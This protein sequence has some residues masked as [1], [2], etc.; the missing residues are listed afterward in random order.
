MFCLRSPAYDNHISL[1][2]EVS[3]TSPA[4]ASSTPLSRLLRHLRGQGRGEPE[5][6]QPQTHALPPQRGAERGLEAAQGQAGIAL[7]NGAALRTRQARGHLRSGTEPA[8]KK[9]T[10][11]CPY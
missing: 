7:G 11:T 2:K 5:Q 1:W 6:E 8:T 4:S 3:W 9:T 10:A